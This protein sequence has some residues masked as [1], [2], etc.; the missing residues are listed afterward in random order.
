MTLA[1]ITHS[2]KTPYLPT[3]AQHYSTQY[4]FTLVELIMVIVLLGVLSAT[5]L[6]R[7]FSKNDF[8]ERI[9]FD[10]TQNAARYAQKLSVATGCKTILA[11]AD[12]HYQLLQGVSC[13]TAP[14]TSPVTNP[15]KGGP[16]T[17][18]KEGV[19]L[20]ASHAQTT[21]NALGVA[22][23]DNTVSVGSRTFSIIAATGFNYDST[24]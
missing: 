4:G 12:N 24:P 9:V 11:I 1:A 3:P 8:D 10:D 7:F 13:N 5:A 15:V 16:Y 17:G 23:S 21:F 19:T 14:F 2:P 6:P 22:D 20:S 18:Y